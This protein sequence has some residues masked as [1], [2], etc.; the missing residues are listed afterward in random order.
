MSQYLV[1]DALQA[2]MSL[3]GVRIE[4]NVVITEDGRSA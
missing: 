4:S 2:F 3:G 1:Q